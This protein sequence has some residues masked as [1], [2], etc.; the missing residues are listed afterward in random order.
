[1]NETNMPSHSSPYDPSA[2]V[3][4]GP[5]E[6]P[7]NTLERE[8]QNLEPL[9]RRLVGLRLIGL[10]GWLLL[11]LVVIAA[12]IVLAVWQSWAWPIVAAEALITVV[13]FGWLAVLIPRQ[14]RRMG[15]RVGET[16]LLIQRGI[17]FQRTTI[18]P[19]GRLQ[20]V[21][22]GQ[23]PL[24]RL[25]GLAT[26][27]LHTASAKSDAVIPG[28]TRARADALRNELAARGEHR[29]AGL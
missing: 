8:E 2:A 1:M 26:V 22:V 5:S 11:P 16:D 10:A 29:L 15:F 20:F 17:M 19:L 9:S 13:L 4:G 23:G 21:D 18:V 28:L 3:P 27:E 25:L 6:P 7:V 14:V 24:E 12:T